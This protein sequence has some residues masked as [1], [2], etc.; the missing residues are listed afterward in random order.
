LVGC[1]GTRLYPVKQAI[2]KQPTSVY[3]DGAI[4]TLILTGI[5]K[6]VASFYAAQHSADF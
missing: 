5:R 3:V 1:F 2:S 6:K 4:T